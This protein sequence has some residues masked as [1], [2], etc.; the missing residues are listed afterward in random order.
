[1]WFVVMLIAL[2]LLLSKTVATGAAAVA[3]WVIA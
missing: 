3:Q 2:L 1:L